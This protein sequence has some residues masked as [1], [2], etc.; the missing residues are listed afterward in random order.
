MSGLLNRQLK[1]EI[2]KLNQLLIPNSPIIHFIRKITSN[3]SSFFER[4]NMLKR[5]RKQNQ[6]T[7]SMNGTMTMLF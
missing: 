2:L 5:Q 3:P 7:Q 6:E 4:K 1:S